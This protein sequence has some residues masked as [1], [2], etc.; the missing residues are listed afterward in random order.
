MSG[1][2]CASC[3]QVRPLQDLLA[4]TPLAR[5]LAVF[6]ACRPEASVRLCFREV[7]A[8]GA[9]SNVNRYHPRTLP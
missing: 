2:V 4:V 9:S 5:P 1:A 7:T 6:Y 3:R 8:V